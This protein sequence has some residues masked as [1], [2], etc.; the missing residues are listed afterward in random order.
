MQNCAECYLKKKNSI[1]AVADKLK[2]LLNCGNKSVGLKKCMCAC[3]GGEG[4]RLLL[5]RID[6]FVTRGEIKKRKLGVSM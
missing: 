1:T 3:G 6:Q 2:L 5:R 4:E